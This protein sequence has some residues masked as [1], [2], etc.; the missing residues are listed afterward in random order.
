MFTVDQ[1]L[2]AIE[3][4]VTPGPAESVSLGE[5]LG[6]VL[7]QPIDSDIDSPPFD[8][9]LMDGFAVRANDV[10]DGTA[11]LTVV[12][13]VTAG[14]VAAKPVAPGQA[15]QIM[16]GAPMPDGGDAVVKI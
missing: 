8:K 16:T 14:Q 2:A 7:A 11:R 1:A 10:A 4:H 3:S 5:A 13:E 9:A 12:D 6:R 15:I